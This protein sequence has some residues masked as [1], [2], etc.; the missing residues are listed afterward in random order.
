LANLPEGFR[1]GIEIRNQD[2]LSPPYFEVLADYNVAHVFSAWTRMPKLDE[3]VKIPEAF[4]ADFTVVRALLAR[5]RSYE[6]AL[7]DLEP[8]E[9]IREPNESARAGMHQ[10]A[11]RARFQKKPAFLFVNNRLEGNAPSTIEA[12]AD[13]LF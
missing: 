4:T 10:I 6:Q 9:L 8:Y 13:S 3:Q 2:Y 5:G 1:Y 11:V 12:V 7:K